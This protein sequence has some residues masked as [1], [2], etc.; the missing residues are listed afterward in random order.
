[1]QKKLL[2]LGMAALL[3]AGAANAA[4]KSFTVNGKTVSVADQKVLYDA[5]VAQGQPAGEPLEKMVKQIAIQNAVL[6]EEAKKA[7]VESKPEVKAALKSTHD[8]ILVD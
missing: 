5:A 8:K 3:A 6:L 2:V 7:R 1:M 4:L